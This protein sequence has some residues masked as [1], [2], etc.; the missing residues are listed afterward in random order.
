MLHTVSREPGGWGVPETLPVRPV[1]AVAFRQERAG[2]CE[3]VSPAWMAATEKLAYCFISARHAFSAA[4]TRYARYAG[5]EMAA[6]NEMIA[7]AVI[8]SIKLKPWGLLRV[9]EDLRRGAFGYAKVAPA[10]WVGFGHAVRKKKWT[11]A[12]GV[13]SRLPA[14]LLTAAGRSPTR[15]R[16]RSACRRG[17]RCG[18]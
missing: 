10:P 8:S 6:S 17:R 11:P 18:G 1:A 4:R 16:T 15:C 3:I 13:H 5:S 2:A 7:T 14:R 12:S 9:M